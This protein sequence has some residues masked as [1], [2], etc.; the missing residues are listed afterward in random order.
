M[1]EAVGD[2]GDRLSTISE[3]RVWVSAFASVLGISRTGWSFRVVLQ[4]ACAFGRNPS[5]TKAH[6]LRSLL[7]VLSQGQ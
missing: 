5:S 6:N 7:H 1:V 3:R 2:T 4:A